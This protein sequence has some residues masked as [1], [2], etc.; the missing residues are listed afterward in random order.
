MV[1]VF[2]M[3]PFRVAERANQGVVVVTPPPPV[4]GEPVTSGATG[5]VNRLLGG[6]VSGLMP[7]RKAS[8]T[9]VLEPPRLFVPYDQPVEVIAEGI[10]MLP[11]GQL[12]LCDILRLVGATRF[13]GVDSPDMFPY[14]TIPSATEIFRDADLPGFPV[15]TRLNGLGTFVGNRNRA[16]F[17]LHELSRAKV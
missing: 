15:G 6:L 9:V 13:V 3:Q 4:L 1:P 10:V 8:P 16:K 14:C 5:V 11:G 2:N 7:V 12:K 17:I